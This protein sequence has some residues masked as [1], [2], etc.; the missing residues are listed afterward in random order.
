MKKNN[1]EGRIRLFFALWPPVEAASTLHAWAEA[2]HVK[3]ETAQPRSGGRVTRASTLHLTLAFLGDLPSDR[4]AS[5]IDC[6]RRVHCA[7]FDLRLDEGR[8][9][10]HNRIVWAGP[11]ALSASLRDLAAQLDLRLKEA[12]YRTEKRDFRAHVTL[13][14]RASFAASGAEALPPFSPVEWRADEF[15]LVRS[16]LSPQGPAYST[17]ARFPL[18]A[19]KSG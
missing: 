17:L 10:E 8:W 6:A 15:V 2:A 3:A 12:G 18:A 9:W 7:P 14:R 13:V 19:K 11:Q 1:A 4:V 5:L 16:V